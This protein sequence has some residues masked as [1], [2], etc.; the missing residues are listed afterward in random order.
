MCAIHT[1]SLRFN[2]NAKKLYLDSATGNVI[3]TQ[4]KLEENQI[5]DSITVTLL[6]KYKGDCSEIKLRIC[7]QITGSPRMM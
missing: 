7:Q 6:L 2:T 4:M 1:H 5:K 3:F